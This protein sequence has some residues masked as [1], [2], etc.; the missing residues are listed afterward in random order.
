MMQDRFVIHGMD[1]LVKKKEVDCIAK[2]F[3]RIAYNC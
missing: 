2:T 3:T 1:S